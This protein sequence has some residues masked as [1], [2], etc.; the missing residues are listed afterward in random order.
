[1]KF[2]IPFFKKIQG[3]SVEGLADSLLEE[4]DAK[5]LREFIDAGEKWIEVSKYIRQADEL[6]KIANISDLNCSRY[7]D[8]D[9]RAMFFILSEVASREEEWLDVAKENLQE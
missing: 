9:P 8:Y 3:K 1:M 4:M 6:E 5:K 2:K 7:K